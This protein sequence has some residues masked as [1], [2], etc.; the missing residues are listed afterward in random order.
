MC[1]PLFESLTLVVKLQTDFCKV[2][3]KFKTVCKKVVARMLKPLN[4]ND[5]IR[6][7]ARFWCEEVFEVIRVGGPV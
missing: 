2:T 7:V 4:V 3:D 1:F 5:G 6:R